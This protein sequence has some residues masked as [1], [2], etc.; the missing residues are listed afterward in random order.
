MEAKKSERKFE[1]LSRT[2]SP[3]DGGEDLEGNQIPRFVRFSLGEELMLL[4]VKSHTFE[5]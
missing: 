4:N 3:G 2:F 1:V 5:L